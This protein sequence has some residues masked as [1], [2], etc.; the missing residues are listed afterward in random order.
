[1]ASVNS[2]TVTPEFLIESMAEEAP[3]LRYIERLPNPEEF[4]DIDPD[5]ALKVLLFQQKNI[6]Q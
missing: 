6:T 1:M 2:P 3:Q 5:A 4:E